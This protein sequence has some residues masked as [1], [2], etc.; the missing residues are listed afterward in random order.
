MKLLVVAAT[1][2]EIE[3]SIDFLNNKKIDFLVTGVGMLATAHKLTKYLTNKKIDL[4]INV[5]VG[6]ILNTTDN[7]GEV[8][9]VA[10]D[11]I[12]DFG[13]EDNDSFIPIESLGF[14]NSL[15]KEKIPNTFLNNQTVKKVT[16]ITSN[17]VHGNKKTII[18]LQKRHTGTIIES[19]E[20]AAVF[21]IAEQEQTNCLQ[22]RS[23]SNYIE[24]RNRNTWKIKEAITNLNLFLQAEIDRI[25]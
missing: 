17:K 5:G 4:I 23:S 15:F 16:G 3:Q 18:E 10:E 9:Q 11:Y 22:F 24:P 25:I 1:I 12:Y 13:A 6:G 14:G 20:G 2:E 21:Y 19:M 7:L 8:Y